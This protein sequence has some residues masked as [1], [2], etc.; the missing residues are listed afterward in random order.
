MPWRPPTRMERPLTPLRAKN[1]AQWLHR[2]AQRYGVPVVVMARQLRTGRALAHEVGVLINEIAESE[3]R[4]LVADDKR[5]PQGAD[6]FDTL[7]R[8]HH[9]ALFAIHKKQTNQAARRALAQ[10]AKAGK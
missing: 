4:R 5:A 10:E 1:S 2:V 9:A 6:L 8:S 3:A 7:V